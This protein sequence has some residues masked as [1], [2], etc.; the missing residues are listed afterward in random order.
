M[1]QQTSNAAAGT[2]SNIPDASKKSPSKRV[3]V[4]DGEHLV[5]W[6]VAETLTLK[7]YEVMQARDATSAAQV[8]AAP[9]SGA[10]LVLLDLWP[11]D[12]DTLR[13]VSFIRERSPN[14]AIILMTAMR[15]PDILDQAEAHRAV[16]LAK[17]F[18]MSQLA[19]LVEQNLR[20]CAA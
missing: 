3:L 6:A 5:C 7:G 8:F 4:V 1:I 2:P 9:G 17:P 11:S 13:L 10:D 14:T 16:V 12:V 19:T 15:S 20:A 18:D